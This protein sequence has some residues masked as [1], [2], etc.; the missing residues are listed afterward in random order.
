M[1][2]LDENGAVDDE[3]TLSGLEGIPPVDTMVV[4]STEAQ[5]VSEP[6]RKRSR[7]LSLL[8][9]LVVVLVLLAGAAGLYWALYL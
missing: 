9:V 6:S 2:A 8:L 1:A 3:D 5:A 7:W 4:P